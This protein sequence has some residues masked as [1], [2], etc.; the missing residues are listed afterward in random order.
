[1]KADVHVV[2]PE[3]WLSRGEAYVRGDGA[4]LAVFGGIPGEAVKARVFGRSGRQVRARALA[5][6]DRPHPQRVTPPCDKWGPCGGCPWMH[7]STRGQ[8]DAHESLWAQAAQEA[9]IVLP[10]GPLHRF[11]GPVSEVRVVWGLSDHGSPRIGVP[12]REGRGLVAIPE[13]Q[14][15]SAPVRSFMAAAAA[16]L[17]AAELWPEGTIQGL[18]A[19]E[20][21]G[22]V[23]VGVRL[24]RFM[25]QVAAWAPTLASTL[26][27]L[28]GVVLEF[29]V[30]EDKAGLGWQKVYGQDHLEWTVGGLRVRV[31]TEEHLP[32]HLGAW[33]ALIEAA[34]RM[35]EVA[36]GD[37]VL[38]L[39]AHVGARAA[40][41][42]R[43]AGWAYGVET[44]ERACLRAQE[45]AATN[46]VAAEF[47]SFSWPEAIED[48]A[49]RFAG[50]RPLVWID[51]GR[52]ELGARVVDAVRGLDPRRVALQ[53]SNP[54]ALA[55]EVARW[56]GLG[57]VLVRM[58]R[59]D[60]D[61]NSPFSEA[62]VVLASPDQSA[63]A[64][65]A[66]RRKIARQ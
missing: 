20:V 51:T 11:E 3:G 65:R 55:R 24:P 15:L 46:R 43:A 1:M 52:K 63:P 47:S 44:D 28:R 7:L 37:A 40:A 66:P 9:G 18:R 35:L 62:V 30:E 25:P 14:K 22:E 5:V 32:R 6:A 16:S 45:N 59:W 42:A 19:R 36:E 53:G 33:G 56:L 12:A 41:L 38:D 29:P 8:Y 64:L 10:P 21:G 4:Q 13:C 54:H 2:T 34:P 17:R 58:E 26:T 61:P 57:F 39:G 31:G 27:E 60:V 50:R 23:L 48:V 49:P